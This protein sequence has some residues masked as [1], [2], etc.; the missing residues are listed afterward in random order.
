MRNIGVLGSFISHNTQ[1]TV[2]RN[3]NPV[4]NHNR[5]LFEV[6][7]DSHNRQSF[8]RLYFSVDTNNRKLSYRMIFSQSMGG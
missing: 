2:L 7:P 8:Y 4:A 5:F 3:N 6:H 1:S